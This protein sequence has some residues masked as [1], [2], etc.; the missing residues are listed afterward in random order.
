[1]SE[2]HSIVRRR[3]SD[4]GSRQERLSW[5]SEDRSSPEPS[6]RSSF[7]RTTPE[8]STSPK[9]NSTERV[10]TPT[11]VMP[12]KGNMAGNQDNPSTVEKEKKDNDK[13]DAVFVT[14]PT[15]PLDE[16][17]NKKIETEL[18]TD[19]K[20]KALDKKDTPGTDGEKS[21][22]YKRDTDNKIVDS[23]AGN[24]TFNDNVKASVLDNDS[25]VLNSKMVDNSNEKSDVN[26]EILHTD[27][28]VT[29]E[30][31]T[32]TYSM[33]SS[34]DDDFDRLE[35]AVI[36]KNDNDNID[37]IDVFS[38]NTGKSEDA[39]VKD[40][41]IKHFLPD[42][43]CPNEGTFL[44]K[45]GCHLLYGSLIAVGVGLIAFFANAKAK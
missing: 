11:L 7:D 2:E 43:D 42:S 6:S 1:M 18:N 17:G 19:K 36:S 5:Q 34:T 30:P 20:E 21:D 39:D 35:D 31:G 24:E 14:E 13:D 33:P 40:E 41:P 37:N 16:S 4:Y 29:R 10:V 38:S 32:P 26:N 8:P 25:S 12:Q 28:S 27:A 22:P 3:V 23:G 9:K 15:T 45:Y 44:E